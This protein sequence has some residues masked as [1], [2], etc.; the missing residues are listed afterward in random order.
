MGRKIPQ[1][2][3]I[4]G[5]LRGDVHA[6]HKYVIRKNLVLLGISIRKLGNDM[7]QLVT[8]MNGNKMYPEFNKFIEVAQNKVIEQAAK[9]AECKGSIN[10][11]NAMVKWFGDNLKKVLVPIV[12]CS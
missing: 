1:T 10:G 2:R 6:L 3:T 12:H 7:I 8:V 5:V 9:F 11:V 4:S